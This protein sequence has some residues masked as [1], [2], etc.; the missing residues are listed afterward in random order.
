MAASQERTAQG[1]QQL[2]ILS[3]TNTGNQSIR[4]GLPLQSIGSQSVASSHSHVLPNQAAPQNIGMSSL[5]QENSGLHMQPTQQQ[6][7]TGQSEEHVSPNYGTSLSSHFGSSQKT[8]PISHSTEDRELQRRIDE[9]KRKQAEF[10]ENQKKQEELHSPQQQTY[11]QSQHPRSQLHPGMLR[12]DNL[13]INGP[14]VS[15][16]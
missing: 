1:T 8:Y 11:Q 16:R 13:I 2:P 4:G 14:S 10:E 15:M 6:T 7:T 5:G 9:V 12:L 3:R